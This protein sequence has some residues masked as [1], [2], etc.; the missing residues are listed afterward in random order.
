MNRVDVAMY[1]LSFGKR[2]KKTLTVLCCHQN[3]KHHEKKKVSPVK[4][5]PFFNAHCS[6]L[7]CGPL[8]QFLTRLD[9]RSYGRHNRF[10]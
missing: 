8:H 9:R 1:F 6:F 3:T 10:R 2:F 7:L 4:T 5:H